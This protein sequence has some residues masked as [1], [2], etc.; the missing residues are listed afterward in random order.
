MVI[1]L[2]PMKG[3]FFF[4]PVSAELQSYLFYIAKTSSIGRKI[5]AIS[6]FLTNKNLSFYF[7]EVSTHLSSK[8]LIKQKYYHGTFGVILGLSNIS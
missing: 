6:K 4:H 5:P 3:H 8:Y 1:L 2:F 7:K